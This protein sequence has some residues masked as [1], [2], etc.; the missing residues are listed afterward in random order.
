MLITNT[1][2]LREDVELVKKYSN[3]LNDEFNLL[4]SKLESINSFGN[5]WT[6]DAAT[7]FVESI[8]SDKIKYYELKNN[9]DS[10]MDLL[11]D[12]SFSIDNS[13]SIIRSNLND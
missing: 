7:K 1:I 3:D 8:K 5:V 4:F 6:G 10:L 12:N 9:I 2:R 13:V 11:N